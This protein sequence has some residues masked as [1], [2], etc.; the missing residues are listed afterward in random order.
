MR[1]VP[2]NVLIVG[3]GLAA[4][5][6]A[7]TLRARGHHGPVRVVCAEPVAP[8]DRPP[9]SKDLLATGAGEPLLRPAAWYSEQEVE[10]LLGRR[11]AS[12]DAHA[13]RVRL[14]DGEALSYDALIVATGS[15]P[16]RLPLLARHPNVHVL[17][18]LADAR[19]LHAALVPGARLAI[20][21]AG[22]IG[23]EVAATARALGV[24]VCLIEAASAPLLGVLGP[25]L[26]GWFAALHRA[27][28]VRV[29][30]DVA[31][32]EARPAVAGAPVRELVLTDGR[33]VAADVVLVAVGVAPETR[34]LAGSPLAGDGIA[35]DEGARTAVPGVYAA[36]DVARPSDPVTG[37][38]V[39]C[40]HWEPAARLGTAA[41]RSILGLDA[42]P[43]PPASFWSD[44]YG[45]RIQLV[46]EAAGAAAFE[47]EGRPDARDF[48]AVLSRRGVLCGALL[49]GR[50]RE[51]A[52]WR[53]RLADAH[54][55]RPERSAA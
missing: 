29:E 8:Y 14:E 40:E 28:G 15:R 47:L 54:P 31:L 19:A 50:P 17:R 34:W 22:F 26:G 43:A 5:R 45:I 39:R 11:A 41:A 13:R 21:G 33:T 7:E 35:V 24:E 37:A 52:K 49:V 48:T 3:G 18:T 51:L 10:L 6:A 36:G 27:E 30:L 20:V 53:R 25:R 46:G 44:Q 42:A 2:D 9:L 32:A 4:Q 12:L 16:R 38:P 1:G 23:Q 55:A